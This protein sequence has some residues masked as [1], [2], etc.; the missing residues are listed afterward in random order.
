MAV[1]AREQEVLARADCHNSGA[2]RRIAGSGEEF[3][4]SAVHLHLVLV[5]C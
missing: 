3:G 1:H 2:C 4:N 5:K